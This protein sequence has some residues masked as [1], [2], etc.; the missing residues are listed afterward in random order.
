[1]HALTAG[2]AVADPLTATYKLDQSNVLADGVVY[3]TVK[4]DAL[5]SLG[6]IKL[7]YTANTAPYSSVGPNFG[8]HTVGFNTDLALTSSQIT[9]PTGWKP[10]AGA[11]LSMFGEF[12]WKMETSKNPSPSV[13][14][15]ITGLGANAT[16]A[17]F[18]L[19]SS[20]GEPQFFAGHIIDF[21]LKG[22]DTTSQWVA[23]SSDP[24]NQPPPPPPGGQGG[25][26]QTP[27]PGTAVLALIGL[28]GLG[29]LRLSRRRAGD[30]PSLPQA[31]HTRG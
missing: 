10:T 22:S 3:G 4:I 21:S 13:T 23:G 1:M 26:P 18:T 19:P 20:G 12:S 6:E 27:E 8:F 9:G 31:G 25:P 28:C 5:P 7:T 30:P 14:L 2:R 24:S 15:L 29:L 17:H 16:L 11:N